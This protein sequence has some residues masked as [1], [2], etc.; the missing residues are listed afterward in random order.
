M[1][2]LDRGEVGVES[3]ILRDLVRAGLGTNRL[4]AACAIG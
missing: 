1:V 4:H 3:R 2:I